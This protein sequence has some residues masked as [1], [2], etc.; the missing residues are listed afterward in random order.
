MADLSGLPLERLIRG[1]G[2][3]VRRINQDSADLA[4]YEREL[5]ARQPKGELLPEEDL[6]TAHQVWRRISVVGADAEP[7][8]EPEPEPEPKRGFWRR[9]LGTTP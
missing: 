1:R 8:P 2:E 7:A 6:L 9:L 3:L 5:L 4:E